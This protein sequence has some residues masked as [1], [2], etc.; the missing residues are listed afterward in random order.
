M[1]SWY[2]NVRVLI[3]C[4]WMGQV[5]ST[6]IF[7]S[8][9]GVGG[10]RTRTTQY[11]HRIQVRHRIKGVEGSR[12][13]HVFLPKPCLLARSIQS[14]VERSNSLDRIPKIPRSTMG[15]R[16]LGGGKER[17][18]QKETGQCSICYKTGVDKYVPIIKP[19]YAASKS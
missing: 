4:V 2:R 7:R 5:M 6:K 8:K 14:D 16:D 19:K 1:H 13:Q 18:P 12:S 10:G 3:D 15:V 17:E 9:W 11:S